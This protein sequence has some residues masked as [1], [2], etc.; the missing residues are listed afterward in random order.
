M[1]GEGDDVSQ[2]EGA[3]VLAQDASRFRSIVEASPV[4]YAI[5]DEHQN[6]TYV[7]PAFVATFGYSRDDI[8]T[9]D[10]WWPR[11]YPDVEYRQWVATEWQA[12]LARAKSSGAPF[13]TFEVR[14]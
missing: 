4:P 14:I 7:N 3:E 1:V 9:L 12:R 13:E 8:P 5:N 10:E 6:I 2:S 11:A